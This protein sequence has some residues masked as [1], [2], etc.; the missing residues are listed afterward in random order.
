MSSA[1]ANELRVSAVSPS[2]DNRAFF[3]N[4]AA[5]QW[6]ITQLLQ[7]TTRDQLH[8][9]LHILG[10]VAS[11]RGDHRTLS[12][13]R[14]ASDLGY[15]RQTVKPLKARMV[16]ANLLIEL[17]SNGGS[18]LYALGPAITSDTYRCLLQ[19]Y[20]DLARARQLQWP[21]NTRQR[22]GAAAPG[23]LPEQSGCSGVDQS[24]RSRGGSVRLI[25]GVDQSERSRVDQSERSPIEISSDVSSNSSQSEQPSAEVEQQAS[26]LTG[27]SPAEISEQPDQ[28]HSNTVL[29]V[30]DLARAQR[31]QK[32]QQSQPEPTSSQNESDCVE[33]QPKAEPLA[34][35]AGPPVES[36]ADGD[37]LIDSDGY[38]G[39]IKVTTDRRG[40]VEM[41]LNLEDG[42]LIYVYD[43]ECLRG[44]SMVATAPAAATLEQQHPDSTAMVIAPG[45][46]FTVDDSLSQ[47][48]TVA[49]DWSDDP[50]LDTVLAHPVDDPS[51]LQRFK[52][53]VVSIIK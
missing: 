42:S 23:P 20:E 14:I 48:I 27:S 38:C 5:D 49:A 8:L 25:Q 40:D 34:A 37:V 12:L 9:V 45:T 17:A 31:Q 30:R 46:V 18:S 52:A 21:F 26:A 1:A 15:S 22:S 10:L 39:F 53:N 29:S 28:Q 36:L 3:Y 4:R 19:Q 11:G 16:A 41:T 7:L 35:W 44:W 43:C 32:Q 51:S 24:E 50:S 2:T 33:S 6:A 47:F 13:R